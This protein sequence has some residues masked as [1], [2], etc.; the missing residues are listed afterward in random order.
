MNKIFH[1]ALNDLRVTFSD[2]SI[3]VN[4]VGIPVALIVLLGIFT[5][6]GSEPDQI[7]IE[8]IDEDNSA[9]SAQFLDELQQTNDT[10]I[11]CPLDEACSNF[12]EDLT[13]EQ[14][15]ER[16]QDRG[17]APSAAINIPVGFSEAVFSGELFDIAFYSNADATQPDPIA[18]S[19]QAVLQRIGGASVA[20][21][22]ALN[23]YDGDDPADYQQQ[24]YDDASQRWVNP[25]A[26][27]DFVTTTGSDTVSIGGFDQSTPGMGSM[28]VMFTVLAGAVVLLKERKEWTLQRLATMPISRSQIMA[29][30]IGARFVM[31]M[32]QF[33]VAFITG[34]V[35]GANLGDDL[36][37]LVLIMM[38]FTLCTTALALLLANFVDREEQANSIITFVVLVAA[39]LGGA[40]WPLEI[41]PDFMQTLAYLSPVGWA[42]DGF[43][44]L[45]FYGGTLVDVMPS[46]IVLT[47]A[48]VVLFGIGVMQFSYTD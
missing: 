22:I 46:I 42:M 23:A 38:S 8:V 27:V 18:Q 14:A 40:W 4:L 36:F 21:R 6:A 31:G 48:G 11:L 35:M 2:N 28:Y 5:G 32:I 41:V 17:D 39:P 15:I 3:W 37:A 13:L 1:I 20:A 9:V 45:M 29:G 30:K 12:G 19:V 7:I 34:A 47:V 24:V 25:P 44:E 43:N 26:D 16:V 10:L 33:T